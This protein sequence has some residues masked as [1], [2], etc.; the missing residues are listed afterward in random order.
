MK[1]TART[2]REYGKRMPN[3]AVAHQLAAG[4]WDTNFVLGSSAGLGF[5]CTEWPAARALV[6]PVAVL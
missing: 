2:V 6:N 4:T 5:G 1:L 3:L